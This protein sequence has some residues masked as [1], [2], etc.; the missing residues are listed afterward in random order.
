MSVGRTRRRRRQRCCTPRTGATGI[1]TFLR[2]GGDREKSPVSACLAY[3]R[4]TQVP[5]ICSDWTPNSVDSN[6]N[7]RPNFRRNVL[8]TLAAR[9]RPKLNARG[10][11]CPPPVIRAENPILAGPRL[12]HIRRQFS[13][14]YFLFNVIHS[15]APLR[16]RRCI[17]GDLSLA[18]TRV[19]ERVPRGSLTIWRLS[20][21]KA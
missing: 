20:Q 8:P 6:S 16:R 10:A 9:C 7:F 19:R 13:L 12:P 11:N 21:V 4:K 2:R 17:L 15:M 18:K 14:A 1:P 5:T 3:P